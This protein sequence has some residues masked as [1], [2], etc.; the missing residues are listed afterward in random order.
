MRD[1]ELDV[2]RV[3]GG[4]RD[5]E[6]P[7][8]GAWERLEEGALARSTGP[9]Q[10][11][12][13]SN[14]VLCLRERSSDLDSSAVK[15]RA[16]HKLRLRALFWG[17]RRFI[18]ET[19]TG[20]LGEKV[21]I[22]ALVRRDGQL[23]PETLFVTNRRLLFRRGPWGGRRVREVSRQELGAIDVTG[24]GRYPFMVSVIGSDG[25][26]RFWLYGWSEAIGASAS[27]RKGRRSQ[28]II[29]G[30]FTEAINASMSS[31]QSSLLPCDL[32]EVT[33]KSV[34]GVP[35]CGF[36]LAVSLIGL[37][38]AAP[39]WL[40]KRES[41]ATYAKAPLCAATLAEPCKH[42]GQAMVLDMSL[43]EGWVRLRRQDGD[44]RKVWVE[45]GSILGATQTGQT[46]ATLVWRGNVT[47][48]SSGSFTGETA[49][50]PA[51]QVGN[52]GAG[53]FL[54]LGVLTLSSVLTMATFI[55]F[56]RTMRITWG[57]EGEAPPATDMSDP[58]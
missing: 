6:G 22:R 51:Y 31:G 45:S 56:R 16:E 27:A 33:W 8:R 43:R 20:E 36:F 42:P 7:D 10:V 14:D 23:H 47:T 1:D 32:A 49:A 25:D 50:S 19:G 24:Q 41:A 2:C 55:E 15:D 53:V 9:T 40:S 38:V 13:Y 30:R 12:G 3:D 35:G 26:I 44:E 4:R 58:Q 54:A 52:A 29:N 28:P 39:A 11:G 17:P 37:S 46:L 34:L 21:L 18:A 57:S 48:V 5:K